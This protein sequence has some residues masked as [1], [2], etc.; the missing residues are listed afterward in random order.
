M[1]NANNAAIG[2]TK[3]EHFLSAMLDA[4]FSA[5]HTGGS[6]VSF[7]DVRHGAGAITLHKLH[8]D[9]TLNYKM[10]KSHA[11]RLHGQF[12]WTSE[13]FVLAEK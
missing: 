13:T 9:P 7:R 11:R 8:P 1:F 10:L 3:W 5:T 12:G 6:C 2:A 4:G